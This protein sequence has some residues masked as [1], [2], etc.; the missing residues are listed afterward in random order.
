MSIIGA[1]IVPHPPLIIPD[2]GGGNERI[3]LETIN[4]YQTISKEIAGLN[5]DTIIISSPHAPLYNDCFYLSVG[6][7]LEGNMGRFHAPF[8]TFHE[9]IDKELVD[10]IGE[11]SEKEHIS[12]QKEKNIELDHGSMVPLYFI[13][14]NKTPFKVVIIGLT[15]QSYSIHYQIGQ[16]IQK[17]SEKLNKRVVYIASG[18][19][20]HKLKKD[21]PYGYVPEGP[22]YDKRLVE[23]CKEGRFNHLFDYKKELLIKASPCGH[24]SFIMMAGA[25]DGYQVKPHF[26]S[27]QD[28]TGVGYTIISYYPTQKDQEREFGN[29]L[30]KSQEDIYVDLATKTIKQYV[31]CH[32]IYDVSEVKNQELLD[33]RAGIFVSIHKNNELRGCI[34]TI[35]P[36]K[37]SIALEIIYNAISAASNDYRF[38]PIEEKELGE[39]EINVDVLSTPELIDSLEELDP[40]KYGI[41]VSYNGK[42]GVLLPDLEGVEDI[43][44]QIDIARSK[45]NISEKDPYKIERFT[46]IRHKE[47]ER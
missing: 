40:K 17:A 44:T 30:L 14:Q 43:Q 12:I 23:D 16:I 18:D 9:T 4:S 11:L 7:Y 32:T 27:Y 13:N 38:D 28:D 42:R 46:V 8:I 26:Y 39:L 1:F 15:N 45:G 37:P 5:P 2:V 25:L 47:K 29:Q 33:N 21:G 19:L 41:I 6:E 3:V 31:R 36:T 20:S 34:G 10:M 35:Q 22:I 24:L